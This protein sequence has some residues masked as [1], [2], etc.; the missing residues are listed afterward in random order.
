MKVPTATGERGGEVQAAADL[1]HAEQHDAQEP[2]LEEEGRQHLVGHQRADDG[3]RPVGE[4]RPVG[5]E[6]VG[7][8]QARDHAHAEGDREDLQ[9]VFE[10]V[11]I[12]RPAGP[13]PQPFEDGEIAREP[14]REGRKDEMERDG[15]GELQAG[16]KSS[17]REHRAW[18]S[19]H[20][21]QCT[22]AEGVEH[23]G[24]GVAGKAGP[25]A[26]LQQH[27]RLQRI[28]TAAPDQ[29]CLAQRNFRARSTVRLPQQRA[30]A[31]TR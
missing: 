12:D 24:N 30:A 28:E 17:R 27:A 1:V 6:L 3:P 26:G 18:R 11:E 22:L 4:H 5:A 2:G 23:P 10:Q 29:A 25:E 15:E 8:D 16:Q 31:R 9:P 20:A 21:E 7:H 14:D 19:P 13:Q